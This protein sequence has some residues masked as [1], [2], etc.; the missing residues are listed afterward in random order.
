MYI[1]EQMTEEEVAVVVVSKEEDMISH[2]IY[3]I[4]HLRQ[5]QIYLHHQY[6]MYL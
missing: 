4:Y 3:N 5:W 2:I 1:E 6:L